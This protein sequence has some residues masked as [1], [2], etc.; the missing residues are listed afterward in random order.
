[1][2]YLILS[3]L[4]A[5]LGLLAATF[6]KVRKIHLATYSLASDIVAIRQETATLFQQLQALAAL[7]HKLALDQPLP[8]LRGWAGSPDFLL[9][10]AG[11]IEQRKPKVILECSSGASTVVCA[12]MLQKLGEGHVYSLEHDETYAA[13]TERLLAR[14]GLT[15][16]ATVI[17]APLKAVDAAPPWYASDAIPA[18]LSRVDLLVVDGPPSPL[19]PLARYP[20]LP[21]LVNILSPEAAILVDD[22]SRDDEQT[23]LGKWRREFPDFAQTVIPCEKGCVLLTRSSASR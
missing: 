19:G 9:V 15:G 8:A 2:T 20:A 12:R 16:W 3:A 14:Y 6:Y 18:S 13:A 1:M 5:L 10:V 4:I 11:E 7:E 23:M 17:R 22:A 21:R